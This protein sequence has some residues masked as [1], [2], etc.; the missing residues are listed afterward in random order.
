MLFYLILIFNHFHANLA[1]M[2]YLFM[3]WV[4]L[5]IWIG[6]RRV[7]DTNHQLYTYIRNIQ[8]YL[9]LKSKIINAIFIFI[10]ILNFKKH[11]SEIHQMMFGKIRV[12]FK[13]FKEKNYLG[14]NI[15]LHFKIYLNYAFHNSLLE[16]GVILI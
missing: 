14:W 13:N 16:N 11:L 9:Y 4:H 2:K 12:L 5:R 8:L 6:I 3:D 15:R 10:K 1:N 7:M